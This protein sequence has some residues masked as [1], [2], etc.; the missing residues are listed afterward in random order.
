MEKAVQ[1]LLIE[2]AENRSNQVPGHRHLGILSIVNV[3]IKAGA[4]RSVAH[5]IACQKGHS[6]HNALI[7]VRQPL[8]DFQIVL[9]RLDIPGNHG[10]IP[11]FQQAAIS[12]QDFPQNGTGVR[13]IGGEERCDAAVAAVLQKFPRKGTFAVPLIDWKAMRLILQYYTGFFHLFDNKRPVPNID[14]I[15][16]LISW[17]QRITGLGL[18]LRRHRFTGILLQLRRGILPN[19]CRGI[20]RVGVPL[21]RIAGV[22]DIVLIGLFQ[23]VLHQ[24][25][26]ELGQGAVG[27]V[28]GGIFPPDF[29][30]HGGDLGVQFVPCAVIVSFPVTEI[31]IKT[32][33]SYGT[34]Q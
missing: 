21:H 5:L 30:H 25:L 14:G 26:P 15:A 33:A 22:G 4:V 28:Q 8:G 31:I 24:P 6:S 3:D 23:N 19:P 18:F 9:A 34:D 20:R 1:L 12:G 17:G 16:L 27:F 11:Q 10:L 2:C 13:Q 29:L 7:G 32:A